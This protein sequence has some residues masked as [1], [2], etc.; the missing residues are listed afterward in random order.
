MGVR[1]NNDSI[2]LGIVTSNQVAMVD[3]YR[4]VLGL[5]DQGAHPIPGATMHDLMCGA[6][7]IKLVSPK[8]EQPTAPGISE[9]TAEV[10]ST[11]WRNSGPGYRYWTILISNL[12]EVLAS[13]R[14]ASVR[15]AVPETEFKSGVHFAIVEDPDGNWIELLQ[16]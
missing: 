9:H 1:L 3:F 12:S 6:S 5:E 14:A 4:D 8:P 16:R 15:I 7:K 2:E 13:C 11:M 10:V